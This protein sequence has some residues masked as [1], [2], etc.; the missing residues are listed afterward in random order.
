MPIRSLR[1]LEPSA[2][3]AS[4]TFDSLVLDLSLVTM[5]HPAASSLA[6]KE[7]VIT[8]IE[9]V[10]RHRI[11]RHFIGRADVV[12]LRAAQRGVARTVGIGVTYDVKLNAAGGSREP[13]PIRG[14]AARAKAR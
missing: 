8:K 2:T 7:V 13:S 12:D 14:E 5:R 11:D 4:T 10:G 1:T 9:D 6:P 3:R